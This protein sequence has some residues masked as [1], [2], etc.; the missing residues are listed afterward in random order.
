MSRRG[1][2]HVKAVAE[3]FFSLLK[4]ECIKRRIYKTRNEATAEIFHHIELF[5]SPN[6]SHGD[7]DG[8]SLLEFEKQYYEKPSS[9]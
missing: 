6:R 9:L 4:T 5:Y 7:N 2:C 8:V 3:S 1:N